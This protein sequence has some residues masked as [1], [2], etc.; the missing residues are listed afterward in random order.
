MVKIRNKFSGESMSD[1]AHTLSEQ[2]SRTGMEGTIKPGM[3]IAVTAGSRGIANIA[4]ITKCVCAEVKE[5]GG[6]PFI[7]PSMGS[8]GG[9]TAEGQI[10]VLESLGVTEAYCEAPIVSSME[11]VQLGETEDGI[12]VY[13]DRH[14][15]QSDGVIVVN[16]IKLHTDFK[17][18]IESGL[19]K[20]ATIGLGK[21][22]QALMM[23]TY[24]IQG[25]R[26][27]MPKAA[28]VVLNS[29]KVLC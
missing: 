5:R 10:E 14:A 25:I 20:M 8:H 24:G 12:P 7:V 15:F 18:N 17:S 6:E 9:A 26:D 21:H 19:M 23:H 4:E 13:M 27:V 2:F 1:I 11:V 16:R 22:K 29:G 28:R 3:R